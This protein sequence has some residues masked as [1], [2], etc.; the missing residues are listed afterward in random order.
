MLNLK[1][2]EIISKAVEGTTVECLCG[3]CKITFKD[4]KAIWRADCC[5]QDCY[6]KVDWCFFCKVGEESIEHLMLCPRLQNMMPDCLKVNSRV[7]VS[8]WLTQST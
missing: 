1:A 4:R 3:K 7:E 8:I 6:Q 5:C 2:G